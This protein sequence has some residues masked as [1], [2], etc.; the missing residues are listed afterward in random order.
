[1]IFAALLQLHVARDLPLDA[2]APLGFAFWVPGSGFRVLGSGV[3]GL[4]V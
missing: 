4:G 3:Q 2:M 1:M